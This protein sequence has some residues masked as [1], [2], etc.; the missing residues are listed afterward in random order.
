MGLGPN[1]GWLPWLVSVLHVRV[2][3][4]GKRY[5]RGRANCRVSF[6]VCPLR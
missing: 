3:G 6:K 2:E 5:R 1:F 4:S